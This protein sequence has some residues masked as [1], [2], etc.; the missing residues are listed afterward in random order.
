MGEKRE[1]GDKGGRWETREGDGRQGKKM[2]D[3]GRR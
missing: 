1:M 3:K 2:G